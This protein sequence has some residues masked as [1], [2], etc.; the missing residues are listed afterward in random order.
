VALGVDHG[1]RVEAG[2]ELAVAQAVATKL[3]V[4]FEIET[5]SVGAGSNLQ[6]RARRARYAA[7]ARA[8][9]RHGA[10]AVAIGHTA[11]DRAETVLLRLLRGAGPRGLAVLPARSPLPVEDPLEADPVGEPALMAIRPFICARRRDVMRHLERHTLPCAVDPSNADARFLRTRVRQELIPL[12]ES[13]SPGIVG[14]LCNLARAVAPSAPDPFGSLSR[15]QREALSRAL[16]LGKKRAIVRVAGGADL[17]LHLADRVA[18]SLDRD[19][20]GP[21]DRQSDR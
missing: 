20:R 12:L 18:R 19:D 5:L 2:A 9:R 7:L 8:A 4:G 14:H 17:T 21:T 13:L 11:D 15:A 6:A 3:G 10:V 1:L 16:A